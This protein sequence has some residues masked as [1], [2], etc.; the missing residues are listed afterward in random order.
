MDLKSVYCLQAF[1]GCTANIYVTVM[2]QHIFTSDFFY[3]RLICFVTA[4]SNYDIK[5]SLAEQD[6]RITRPTCHPFNN[7]KARHDNP[8]RLKLI[9]NGGIQCTLLVN[10]DCL[11]PGLPSII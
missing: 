8:P 2:N 5:R 3:I 7:W 6:V 4:T 10:G 9:S 11:L 1:L